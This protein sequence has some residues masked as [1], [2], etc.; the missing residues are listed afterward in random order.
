MRN[1]GINIDRLVNNLMKDK[2]EEFTELRF[3]QWLTVKGFTWK[4]ATR[5]EDIK[6]HWDFAVMIRGCWMLFDIKGIKK[7][8]RDGPLNEDFHWVE[9]KNVRGDIGWLFG[10]AIYIIFETFTEYIFVLREVLVKHMEIHTVNE[11]LTEKKLY[12]KYK[13]SDWD[14]DDEVV[15]IPTQHLRDIAAKI[16]KK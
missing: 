11:V 1:M 15:L 12:H 7:I 3:G 8:D 5:D 6:E 10:K 14:R 2:E 4:K 13:R 9:Y 16:I